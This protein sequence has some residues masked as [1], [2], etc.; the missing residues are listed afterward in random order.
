MLPPQRGPPGPPPK[1]ATIP[2]PIASR[3]AIRAPTSVICNHCSVT[4]L[5]RW[6]PISLH[7][8]TGS[9]TAGTPLVLLAFRLPQGPAPG[10]D[11]GTAAP[12]VEERRNEDGRSE[13]SCQGH[14]GR[15]GR[16]PESAL[17]VSAATSS[18]HVSSSSPP[19]RSSLAGEILKAQPPAP[20]AKGPLAERSAASVL[21][22]NPSVSRGA[23]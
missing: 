16:C 7:Q 18:V 20:G 21:S 11:R 9:V 10:W 8:S 4:C 14:T 22:L 13:E 5:A 3:G 15:K 19:S 6:C 2:V 1:D 17:R 23:H 12:I